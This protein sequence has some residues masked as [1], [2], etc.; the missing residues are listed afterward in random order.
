MKYPYTIYTLEP[1]IGYSEVTQ[2]MEW[3][4]T[5]EYDE[6][7]LSMLR[8]SKREST[9]KLKKSYSISKVNS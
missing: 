5:E 4:I 8:P 3:D 1:S 9:K 6:D 7:K 2:E